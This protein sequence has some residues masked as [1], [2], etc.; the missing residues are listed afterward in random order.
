MSKLI[1]QIAMARSKKYLTDKYGSDF[2]HQFSMIS[3]QKLSDIVK[4]VPDIGESIFSFNYKFAPAY[5]SW[6]K[7]FIELG[8]SQEETIQNIW[9]MNEKMMTTLPKRLLRYTGKAYMTSFRNKASKHMERQKAGELHPYDWKI[10]YRDIDKNTF[11]IDITECAFIKLCR[12]FN[13][14]NLLPGICRIDYLSANLMGNGFE[15]TKTLAD[16]DDC[17]NCRYQVVGSCEWAPEKGFETR[18]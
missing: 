6:Y 2:Y 10:S 15:R 3:M 9:A 4:K 18:K 11:E 7:S 17:C 13:A 16:G 14:E 8:V 5:I 1:F 12:D